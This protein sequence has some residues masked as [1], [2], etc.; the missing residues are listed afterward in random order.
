MRILVILGALLTCLW[1]P[2]PADAN[3]LCR[4]TGFCLYLS[5][6]FKLAVVDAETGKPLPGVYAW[7]EW[8][9][10][11]AHGI[12]GALMVQDANSSTDG[13]LTFPK[14]GPKFGS[15]AGLLRGTDPAVILFKPGY[16]TLLIENDV[17]LGASEHAAIRS[18]SRHGHT[19]RLQPFR[20][21]PAEWV[22][23]LRQ[24]AHPTLSS[25]VSEAQR[26]RFRALYLRRLQLVESDLHR[27]SPGVAGVAAFGSS[28]ELDRRFLTGGRR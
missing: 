23:Q 11:G 10:Y 28:L 24:L 18:M 7:A 22:D 4:W 13:H 2:A 1:I 12:G 6:G 26:D 8:V 3:V 25:S 14:W 19:M 21:S 27:M 15:R 20:G 5:P 16:A 17:P 9:Q